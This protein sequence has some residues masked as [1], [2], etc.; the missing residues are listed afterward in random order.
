M[1]SG[2][3]GFFVVVYVVYKNVIFV[4]KMRA[5]RWCENRACI[6]CSTKC[7]CNWIGRYFLKSRII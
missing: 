5:F 4:W 1:E 3:D 7:F 2:I 6:R